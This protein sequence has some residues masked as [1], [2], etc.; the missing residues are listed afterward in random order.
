MEYTAGTTFGHHRLGDWSALAL[1][2]RETIMPRYFIHTDDGDVIHRD[3]MGHDLPDS[4]AARKASLDALPDIARDK[5]PDGDTRTIS[6]T[7]RDE[8]GKLV[9]TATLTLSGKRGPGF[10][11]AP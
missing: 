5:I 2:Y 10:G 1:L 11:K 9:Y 6:A 3:D 8:A 7:A 4:E